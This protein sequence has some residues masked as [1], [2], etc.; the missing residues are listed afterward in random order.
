MIPADVDIET[1]HNGSVDSRRYTFCTFLIMV[2]ESFVPG[3][4][5]DGD[6]MY[7][8]LPAKQCYYLNNVQ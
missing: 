7:Q 3:K 8:V 5:I 2:M 1:L 4:S 6:L